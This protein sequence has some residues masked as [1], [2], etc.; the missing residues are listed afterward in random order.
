M[1]P[2]IYRRICPDKAYLK[3]NISCWKECCHPASTIVAIV[4]RPT[5]SSNLGRGREL[6][7]VNAHLTVRV[8]PFHPILKGGVSY[9]LF[10]CIYL[11]FY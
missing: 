8:Q 3:M 9:L 7:I 10:I 11:K 5:L 6:A 2:N 1:K 4:H